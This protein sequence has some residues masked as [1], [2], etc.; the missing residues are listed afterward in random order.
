[1]KKKKTEP[2]LYLCIKKSLRDHARNNG[3]EIWTIDEAVKELRG[4]KGLYTKDYLSA[5]RS[6]VNSTNRAIKELKIFDGIEFLPV[7]K[8][9][10][11]FFGFK[12]YDKNNENDVLN[13]DDHEQKAINLVHSYGKRAANI[14]DT[15]IVLELTSPRKT[16]DKL[17]Q[18]SPPKKDMKKYY[19]LLTWSYEKNE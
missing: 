2:A 17:I 13:Y 7:L 1:M 11:E 9:G 10:R 14:Y 15:G 12:I 5:R 8:N 16:K 19:K 3:H 18:I 6:I 4:H